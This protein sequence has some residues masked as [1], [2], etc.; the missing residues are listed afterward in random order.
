MPD[1]Y[2]KIKAAKQNSY[3]NLFLFQRWGFFAPPPTFNDRLI[4]SYKSAFDSS[5]LALEVLKDIYQQKSK[6]APFNTKEDILDYVLSNSIISLSEQVLEFYDYKRFALKTGRATKDTSIAGI[7]KNEMENT[8]E[9]MTLIKYGKLVAKERNILS[10]KDSIG[11]I[12]GRVYLPQFADR[13]KPRPKQ[14]DMQ[15]IFSSKFTALK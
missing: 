4:Y 5:V 13:N 14:E 11:F 2:L 10:S 7:I 8:W 3:F 12:I 9:Y 15:I 6:K 1:N